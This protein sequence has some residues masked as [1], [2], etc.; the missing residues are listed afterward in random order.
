MILNNSWQWL[1]VE[2]TTSTNDLVK[3]YNIPPEAK[4]LIITAK[5][6]TAG[7]GRRGRQWISQT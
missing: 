3:K 2:E 5:R 6:Q 1:N 4:A 7:R